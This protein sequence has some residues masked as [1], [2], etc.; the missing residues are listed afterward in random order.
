[1]ALCT[2]CGR[3]PRPKDNSRMACVPCADQI[4]QAQAL[5]RKRR[6]ASPSNL[7]NYWKL[8]Y[9]KGHVIGL[10]YHDEDPLHPTVQGHYLRWQETPD[11][12]PKCRTVNL[13]Q[14]CE[15]YD[16]GQIRA[17]KEMVRKLSPDNHRVRRRKIEA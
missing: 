14:W 4:E 2:Q 6:Q 5:E 16:K 3:R 9:W 13:N 1:M 15:G 12:L 17:M 11:G 10:T 8:L 7:S